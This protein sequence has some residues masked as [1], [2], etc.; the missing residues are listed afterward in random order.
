[1]IPDDYHRGGLAH[2]H[3][4]GLK[5]LALPLQSLCGHCFLKFFSDFLRTGLFAV[6]SATDKHQLSVKLHHIPEIAC[7]INPPS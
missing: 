3:A 2:I 5:K 6:R 4:F 1:M 7:I